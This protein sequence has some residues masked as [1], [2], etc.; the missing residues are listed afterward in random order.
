M[1]VNIFSLLPGRKPLLKLCYGH[2]WACRMEEVLDNQTSE[3][4]SLYQY[5]L[6]R[7]VNQILRLN[8]VGYLNT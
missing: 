1:R 2:D 3:Q 4:L 8:Y 5:Q 6:L 7:Y